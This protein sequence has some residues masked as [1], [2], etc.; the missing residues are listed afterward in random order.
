MC[1]PVPGPCIRDL[2]REIVTNMKLPF[3]FVLA[4]AA[5][6]VSRVCSE[7]SNC[8]H[9]DAVD[10]KRGVLRAHEA[11][12]KGRAAQGVANAL[13][14]FFHS[15]CR[16]LLRP[17]RVRG[18]PRRKGSVQSHLH[19]RGVVS[20]RQNKRC[21]RRAQTIDFTAR[22]RPSCSSSAPVYAPRTPAVRI[23]RKQR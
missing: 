9:R 21:K 10:P 3:K 20:C 5:T 8:H 23:Q 2:R 17:Q 6:P 18:R 1:S 19:D 22:A 12:T 7:E 4:R 16:L 13:R 14:H 11:V 15:F